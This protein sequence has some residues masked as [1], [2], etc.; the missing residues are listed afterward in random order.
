MVQPLY[1]WEGLEL[2]GHSCGASRD[3][4]ASGNVSKP[5]QMAAVLWSL[6][7]ALLCSLKRTWR[8]FLAPTLVTSGHLTAPC[9]IS[10]LL[11]NDALKPAVLSCHDFFVWQN[12]RR[13]PRQKSRA[14]HMDYKTEMC[15]ILSR[16]WLQFGKRHKNSYA[17]YLAKNFQLL[18]I[19]DKPT[20]WQLG[21][22]WGS[23]Q[24]I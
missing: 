14:L 10:A 21:T 5:N 18:G 1:S 3:W 13:Q 20:S 7:W 16:S 2:I 4:F 11:N 15:V 22:I 23:Y 24:T 8:S 9:F 6:C 19:A 12:E 17:L